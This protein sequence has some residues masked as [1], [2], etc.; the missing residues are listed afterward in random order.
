MKTPSIDGVQNTGVSP[1]GTGQKLRISAVDSNKAAIIF[2]NFKFNIKETK[3]QERSAALSE[4]Q[5]SESADASAS[6]ISAL[7]NTINDNKSEI[8]FLTKIFI[9][10]KAFFSVNYDTK[11]AKQ[12]FSK[13]KDKGDFLKTALKFIA[14]QEKSGDRVGA[15]NNMNYLLK[16][17]QSANKT[18]L[19]VK[20]LTEE[21]PILLAKL[22]EGSKL[23]SLN[24][25][26][27]QSNQ[28]ATALLGAE[29]DGAIQLAKLITANKLPG[30]K[31]NEEQPK[32]L[33]TTLLRAGN[34]GAIQLAKLITASK[35]PGLN[36]DGEQSK[37]LA[38]ALAGTEKEGVA[39]LQKLIKYGEL[40]EF[41]L[42]TE[43]FSVLATALIEN[44]PILLVLLLEKG[45]LPNLKL[46]ENQFNKF[47]N[48]LIEKD[49]VELLQLIDGGKL[50][51]LKL[52]GKQLK[53][54]ADALIEKAPIRLA[55][56]LNGG[57]LTDL[58]LDGGQSNKLAAVLVAGLGSKMLQLLLENSKLPK[59]QLN[60]QIPEDSKRNVLD[61][62]K[63]GVD[64]LIELGPVLMKNASS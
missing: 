10:L 54:F 14:L 30:L 25:N 5:E 48:F 61:L 24:L 62:L 11:I 50:P 40:P 16:F 4:P 27:E 38:M 32:A 34:D 1:T 6:A 53:A 2:K 63:K 33:A 57:K 59:F 22:L 37:E 41:T 39:L 26:E 35:L 60:G 12:A 52:D 23:Q 18:E 28:L 58:K 64:G 36:L 45:K 49:P 9:Q 29:N 15:A 31:L 19:F 17:F 55:E 47:V 3:L 43:Q 44:D 51:N 13:I 21:D 7:V 46:E 8:G 42:S 56:L 20:I